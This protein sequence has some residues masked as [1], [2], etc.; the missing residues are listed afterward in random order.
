[1]LTV[2][3]LAAAVPLAQNRPLRPLEIYVIDVEGGNAVL[4]STPNNESLLIDTGNGGTMRDVDRIMNAVKDA[5]LSAIDLLITTHYHGDHIG[6]LVELANR[7]PIRQFIDHGPNVQPN[8]NI[9]LVLQQYAALHARA[10]HM[11]AKPGDRLPLSGIDARIVTSAGEAI[12][13][14]LGGGGRQNPLCAAF[15]PKDPDMGENAQSV[16]TV[17]TYGRFRV[18]HLGDLTWNK[19]FELMCPNNRIG[20]VDLFLVSHH[21]LNV[22]NSEVLV[23]ALRPRVAIMNNGIRKGGQ[24]DTMR[25]LYTS[26]GLED[27]WQI[28]FAQL[29]GQEFSVPG[30]FIA[31]PDEGPTV[32]IAPFVPPQRGAAPPPA[33][34][35]PASAPAPAPA[36]APAHNGQAFWFKISAQPDG[37][38]AVTNSRNGFT[39]V[40]APRSN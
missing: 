18:V 10:A 22:S 32:S 3:T 12:R 1:M 19:E 21:G 31:N 16:G 2:A 25:V 5:G 28:H 24:P 14:N 35:P 6:G 27:L 38:F 23:H 13:T 37:T 15:R 8:A 40:Y 17:L 11:V 9:D 34:A 36:P 29:G 39:K 33:P 26:P 30:V 20:T 4:F 7:I